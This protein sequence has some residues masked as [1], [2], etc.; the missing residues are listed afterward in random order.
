MIE[1]GYQIIAHLLNPTKYS[2]VSTD[3]HK[4][5]Q[6]YVYGNQCNFFK[7]K[8]YVKD[9]LNSSYLGQTQACTGAQGDYSTNK[10]HSFICLL[11]F[12]SHILFICQDFFFTY[13]KNGL[14]DF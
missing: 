14:K 6:H 8:D 12:V 11:L 13:K 9:S 4:F 3:D 7:L 2:K 1:W 10:L 5:H